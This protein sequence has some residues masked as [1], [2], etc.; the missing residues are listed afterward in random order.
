MVAITDGESA[1]RAEL[2]AF[3]FSVAELSE[4]DR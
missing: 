2:S 1:N 3:R 4:G